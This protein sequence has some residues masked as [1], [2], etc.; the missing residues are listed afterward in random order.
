MSRR[1]LPT[2]TEADGT[3]DDGSGRPALDPAPRSGRI[4]PGL[5]RL[6]AR[7]SENVQHAVAA[8][9]LQ[10]EGTDELDE[11]IWG[12]AP[13]DADVVEQSIGMELRGILLEESVRTASATPRAVAKML[14]VGIDDVYRR[15]GAGDLLTIAGALV[16]VWQLHGA[17]ILPG[18]A[19][20]HDSYPGDVTSLSLWVAQPNDLLGGATPRERLADGAVDHVV[21]AATALAG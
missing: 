1:Q 5:Q 12:P 6:L 19:V 10:A 13:D 14:S 15:I 7:Q 2:I 4:A 8:A 11:R 3:D 20:V 18:I 9:L 16:P 21:G 17:S